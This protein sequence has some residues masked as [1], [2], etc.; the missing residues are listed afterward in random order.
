MKNYILKYSSY[1]DNIFGGNDIEIKNAYFSGIKFVNEHNICFLYFDTITVED[2][3]IIL[4]FRIDFES[5][6][7][8]DKFYNNYSHLFIR[9]ITSA[10]NIPALMAVSCFYKQS[11]KQ[12][13][14]YQLYAIQ[15]NSEES[16]I[17]YR[18]DI[19]QNIFYQIMFILN[20]IRNLDMIDEGSNFSILNKFNFFKQDI[21]TI[22]LSQYTPSI[23]DQ[24]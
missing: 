22:N 15:T 13:T 14:W 3:P 12:D 16:G 4:S 19:W 6:R 21:R 2:R 7:E 20:K 11:N 8:F 5:T 24:K 18:L 23:P 9:G 17:V 10:I 1:S